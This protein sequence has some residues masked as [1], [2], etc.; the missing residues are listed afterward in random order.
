MPLPNDK[1]KSA[2]RTETMAHQTSNTHIGN[3]EFE[4]R[5]EMLRT[6]GAVAS[7]SEQLRG[8]RPASARG[9]S[10]FATPQATSAFSMAHQP[11]LSDLS[12]ATSDASLRPRLS[13][14]IVFPR[15]LGAG[16]SN[17]D[18]P[19][20]AVHAPATVI[21]SKELATFLRKQSVQYGFRYEEALEQY[22]LTK[23]D[24]HLTVQRLKNLHEAAL[25]IL[26][27]QAE[28]E[29]EG[30]GLDKDV[31]VKEDEVDFGSSPH[32][33]GDL[34]DDA[35]REETDDDEEEMLNSDFPPPN[36]AAKAYQLRQ[37]GLSRRDI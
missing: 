23:G 34:G 28:V 20:S 30:E 4:L 12:G 11:R 5:R 2:S 35:G 15:K 6:V 21:V 8:L 22:R 7:P 31:G 1:F 9:E 24:L 3:A 37:R 18:S 19:G 10:S 16:G 14:G 29:A 26:E 32:A 33:R 13:R 17:M 36:S 25:L 27:D